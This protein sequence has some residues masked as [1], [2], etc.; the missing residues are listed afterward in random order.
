MGSLI[1]SLAPTNPA[2]ATSTSWLPLLDV[3][4]EIAELLV[5]FAPLDEVFYLS[6]MVMILLGFMAWATNKK[7]SHRHQWG[8]RIFALG[9]VFA[10][11]GLNAGAFF[12]LLYYIMGQ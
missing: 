4:S 1:A 7:P 5:Y 3:Q 2:V 6:G 10:I 12:S 9:I 8:K 11:I